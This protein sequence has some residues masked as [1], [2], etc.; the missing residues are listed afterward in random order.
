[1]NL[2]CSIPS[3][4]LPSKAAWC[5]AEGCSSAQPQTLGIFF[6]MFVLFSHFT[7]C[8]WPSAVV[9]L[10]ASPFQ[11]KEIELPAF[12]K[13]KKPKRVTGGEPQHALDTL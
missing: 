6:L 5:T 11:S 10:L 4:S 3:S 9:F 1:M 12:E 2:Y 13:E 7:V 8:V